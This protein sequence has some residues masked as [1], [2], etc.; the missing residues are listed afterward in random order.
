[1]ETNREWTERIHLS[2]E[3][4]PGSETEALAVAA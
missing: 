4:E 1:M 3:E 2:M